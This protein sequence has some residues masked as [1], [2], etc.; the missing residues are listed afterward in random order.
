MR[1]LIVDRGVPRKY[2][3]AAFVLACAVTSPGGSEVKRAAAGGSEVKRAAAGG[4]EVKRA[5]AG[6][7][8]VKRYLT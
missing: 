1:H 8:E 4:S 6:G 7:S 3:L 2:W 5:T